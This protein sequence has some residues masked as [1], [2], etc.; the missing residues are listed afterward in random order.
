MGY[1]EQ[2]EVVGGRPARVITSTLVTGHRA[3]GGHHRALVAD[4]LA[5]RA[6]R[7]VSQGESLEVTVDGWPRSHPA[8]V[9]GLP[10]PV[11]DRAEYP[12]RDAMRQAAARL[13]GRLPAPAAPPR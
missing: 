8:G 2:T 5:L 1:A 9:G 12:M 4:Y 6:F 3:C 13:T 7:E 10:S 11:A